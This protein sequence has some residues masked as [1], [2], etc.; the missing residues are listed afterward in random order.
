MGQFRDETHAC[1][2]AQLWDTLASVLRCCLRMVSELIGPCSDNDV[3]GL[4]QLNCGSRSLVVGFW[5]RLARIFG[6]WTEG[7]LWLE[8]V[9]VICVEDVKR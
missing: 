7:C 3:A 6:L 9:L 4:G 8:K 2:S 5:G 1:R